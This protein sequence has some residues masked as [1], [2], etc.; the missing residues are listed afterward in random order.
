[1]PVFRRSGS[2]DLQLAGGRTDW[3]AD[4]VRPLVGQLITEWKIAIDHS[5][6]RYVRAG[7]LRRTYGRHTQCHCSTVAASRLRTMAIIPVGIWFALFIDLLPP[8]TPRFP[9]GSFQL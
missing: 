4:R 3:V 2:R 7:P 9:V 5:P 6:E 8:S 1:M